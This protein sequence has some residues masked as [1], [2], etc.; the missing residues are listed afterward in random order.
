MLKNTQMKNVLILMAFI[1]TFGAAQAQSEKITQLKQT[2]EV[3]Q[4]GQFVWNVEFY[5]QK[6]G[7]FWPV[8]GLNLVTKDNEPELFDGTTDLTTIQARL[9]GVATA[10]DG[11]TGGSVGAYQLQGKCLSKGRPCGDGY[12]YQYGVVCVARSGFSF[13]FTHANEPGFDA[14]YEKTKA[15]SGTLFFLPSIFRD[16]KFL[17][18]QKNIDKVLVRRTTPTGEQVGVIIFDDLTSCDLVREIVLGLDREGKSQ[19]THIYVLD[20]GGTWGQSCKETNGTTT[21]LGTRDP[22][23]VRAYLTIY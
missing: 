18:S 19:T 20:G 13:K 16:G 1:A 11:M 7:E 3:F 17:S 21:L 6:V 8:Q 2:A 15:D 9:R 10:P 5:G 23:A 22:N 12:V 14:L 4:N